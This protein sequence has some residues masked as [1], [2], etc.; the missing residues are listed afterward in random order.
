MITFI[1]FA[2]VLTEITVEPNYT[3]YRPGQTRLQ[4]PYIMYIPSYYI[5]YGYTI[6]STCTIQKPL[7][8]VR[9]LLFSAAPHTYL[10]L[11]SNV[12]IVYIRAQSSWVGHEIMHSVFIYYTYVVFHCRV[13]NSI[14]HNVSFLSGGYFASQVIQ[15]IIISHRYS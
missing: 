12:C 10:L 6:L 7:G 15:K 5:Q 9:V 1:I 11:V 3:T 14:L 4:T 2:F 8:S 13:R